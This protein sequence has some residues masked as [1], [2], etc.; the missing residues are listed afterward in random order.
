MTACKALWTRALWLPYPSHRPSCS[1]TNTPNILLSQDLWGPCFLCREGSFLAYPCGIFSHG[2]SLNDTFSVKKSLAN[3]FKLEST[4][5]THPPSLLFAIIFSHNISYHPKIQP[6]YLHSLLSVTSHWRKVSQNMYLCLFITTVFLVPRTV[7]I[8]E[9]ALSEY[10]D[11]VGGWVGGWMLRRGAGYLVVGVFPS[12]FWLFQIFTVPSFEQVANSECSSET[13][14]R[15]TAD[16]CSWRCATSS[17]L[18]RHPEENQECVLSFSLQIQSSFYAQLQAST[19]KRR[20]V[21]KN[22]TKGPN[23]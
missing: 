3:F 16:L 7:P 13:L 8:T 12:I 18:G 19:A 22:W 1:S 15:F 6:I 21:H 14:I 2:A 17:P 9:W 11:W 5:P 23:S 20:T 10:S 4:S